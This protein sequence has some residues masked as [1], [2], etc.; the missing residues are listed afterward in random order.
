M[1]WLADLLTSARNEFRFRLNDRQARRKEMSDA[2]S[3][4]PTDDLE[5]ALSDA[6]ERLGVELERRFDAPMRANRA[7]L[8]VL[9]ARAVALQADHA[10]L[11]RDHKG[12]L[13]NAYADLDELKA[14]MA[15][16]KRAVI[17]AYDEMNDAKARIS[18]WHNR[19]KSQIPIYG[20]RGKPIPERSLF[21]FSH[22]DLESAKRDA[23]QASRAIEDA[24]RA[25]DRVFTELSECGDLIAELKQSRTR[26]RELIAAGQTRTKVLEDYAALQPEINRLAGAE[27]RMQKLR[28]ECATTGTIASEVISILESIRVA[29]VQRTERLR[30]FDSA[31]ARAARRSISADHNAIPKNPGLNPK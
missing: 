24:K 26:R 12:E 16:A 10:I 15:A 28:D 4:F 25:R 1:N 5:A 17:E 18:S 19:S 3:A 22:S 7:S 31:D 20:K 29:H 2:E 23:D 9:S 8:A 21:F 6:H 27:E 14:R 11:V 13:D 30:A